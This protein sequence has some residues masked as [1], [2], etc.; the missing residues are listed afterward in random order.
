MAFWQEDA[1]SERLAMVQQARGGGSV[2][3]TYQRILKKHVKE[4]KLELKACTS[5]TAASYDRERKK[6]SLRLATLTPPVAKDAQLAEER[7]PTIEEIAEVDYVVCSTGSAMSFANLP[8]LE[9]LLKSHPIEMVAA[10]PRLTQDLQWNA[11]LP[12]FVVGAYAMLEV[13]SASD[14][15]RSVC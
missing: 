12:L 5:V 14:G 10:F 4:E 9:P 8:F 1:R 7:G 11:D 6:W 2:N 13:S 3:P 15:A